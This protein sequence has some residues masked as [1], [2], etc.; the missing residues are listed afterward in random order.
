MES[1]KKEQDVD[2]TLNDIEGVIEKEQAVDE[3]RSPSRRNNKYLSLEGEGQG[4]G[5]YPIENKRGRGRFLA[6][7]RDYRLPTG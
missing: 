4:W 3:G 1:E 6:P 2:F 7:F 5:S